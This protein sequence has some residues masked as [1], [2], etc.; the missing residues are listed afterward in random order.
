ML[1]PVIFCL[2]N[3]FIAYRLCKLSCPYS[4]TYYCL[5]PI[6][7]FIHEYF[8][9]LYS[10]MFPAYLPSFCLAL[11]KQRWE[12]AALSWI[13]LILSCLIISF[14]FG[15]YLIFW[16]AFVL[17]SVP[18]WRWHGRDAPPLF[19]ACG[20]QIFQLLIQNQ[21]YVY[22]NYLGILCYLIVILYVFVVE[23]YGYLI[24]Q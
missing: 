2:I 18:L 3:W 11:L 6:L 20:T 1:F 12:I 17:C 5:Y 15:T 21:S 8:Q 7:N 14:P 9:H 10:W 13:S 16:N 22:A 19:T 23:R 24:P 4:S